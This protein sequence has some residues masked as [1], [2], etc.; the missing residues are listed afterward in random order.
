MR[1]PDLRPAPL[2][3]VTLRPAALLACSLA[4][5]LLAGPARADRV[6]G[7]R[8][9]LVR[10][11]GHVIDVRI[12]RGAARLIV[13]RT[14][15]NGGPRHDQATFWIDLPPGA[16]ATGLRTLG[17]KGGQPFWFEGELM[18]AEAAA[19]RYRELTGIGG[20]YPKDPALLSWRDQDRLALQV[21]PVPPK[22]PKTVEYTL[23]V[24][25]SYEGGRYHV[26]L[27]RI[28]TEALRAAAIVSPA[29]A[30]DAVFIDGRRSP[31]GGSVAL[32]KDETDLAVAPRA[33]AQLD[34]AL[35]AIP[36]SGGRAVVRAR[37]DAAPRLS[38]VPRGA[39]V[40]VALDASRSLSEAEAAAEVAAARAY[41][42]HF[43]G[44]RVE[45]LTFS[46]EVKALHGR[47]VPVAQALG[48]LGRLTIERAN[49]SGLDAALARADALLAALPPGT[50]RR[51][52]ALTDLR[53][54]A[55]LSP[56]A[57]Q[58]KLRS[59]AILHIEA[60]SAG[61]P[62]LAR[63]DDDPWSVV[64]RATG[65]L[66]WRGAASA[67]ID[68]RAEQV[69]VY[70]ELARPVRVHHP[71]LSARGID[72]ADLTPMPLTLDEGQGYEHLAIHAAASSSPG[73]DAAAAIQ[74]EL[75]GELWSTPIQRTL[76]PD[77]AEGRRW[78]ALVFGSP[79]LP[80]LQEA[81]MMALALRGR[82]VSPVTS[83]LAIEPGV[84]PS[85]EGL[86][87]VASGQ[88]FG[89]GHGRLGASH[90]A[91]PVSMS[92]F[93]PAGHLRS[94]LAPAW[95]ACG[96]AGRAADITVET[97]LAEV[98]DVPRVRVDG[99]EEPVLGRCLA[100]AAW[101]LAL[102]GGFHREWASWDVTL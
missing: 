37:I 1:S 102:P 35:A 34:A 90:R 59:G 88:G 43:E 27:P 30:G 65:G 91:R 50:P 66:L 53:T 49:G 58:G 13:R 14:V 96:G 70:E 29:R 74:I 64:P 45:V 40:V 73:A 57:L 54:R 4:A 86:E 47:L 20:Y 76:S 46:R 10:E 21:F 38:E 55:S 16:V 22:Q 6:S 8:S 67:E 41:L 69:R 78:S 39:A 79:L 75:A 18:E 60:L 100:E 95:R 2:R 23:E 24:P 19:A 81:E 28:G 51:I 11:A 52:V 42:S 93:D 26:K 82:A 77:A 31:P 71:A 83:Y 63:D 15:F 33:P 7:A 48:A 36:L 17:E 80:D 85:T 25:A 101:S 98:V 72:A 32:D 5:A 9:D 56:A 92:L 61:A 94:A 97:T 12:D 89:S 3:P 84:R 68:D 99:K 62:R 87:E 44:A